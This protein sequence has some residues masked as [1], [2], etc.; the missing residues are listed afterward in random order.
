MFQWSNKI[1]EVAIKIVENTG[2]TSLKLYKRELRRSSSLN[3]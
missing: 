2:G 1:Q 3:I